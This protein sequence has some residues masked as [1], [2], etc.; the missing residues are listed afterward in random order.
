M[1]L[2]ATTVSSTRKYAD[3]IILDRNFFKIPPQEI[4]KLESREIGRIDDIFIC[5]H[6]TDVPP[7]KCLRNARIHGYWSATLPIDI[8]RVWRESERALFRR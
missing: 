8:H 3:F 5:N 7:G 1:T 6:Y 4:A 2:P